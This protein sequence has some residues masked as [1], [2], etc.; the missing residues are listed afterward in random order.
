[1][2]EIYIVPALVIKSTFSTTD[3]LLMQVCSE[4]LDINKQTE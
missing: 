1:M 2:P 4:N 3:A